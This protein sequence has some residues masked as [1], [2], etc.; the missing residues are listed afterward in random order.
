VVDEVGVKEGAAAGGRGRALVVAGAAHGCCGG[1]E[2][3][4]VG[5]D[6]VGADAGAVVAGEAEVGVAD[7]ADAAVA[8][9]GAGVVFGH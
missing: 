8:Q 2:G 4:G 9:G 5:V 3:P 1:E 7:G 6:A